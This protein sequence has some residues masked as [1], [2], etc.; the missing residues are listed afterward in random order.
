MG[1]LQTNGVA[2][3]ADDEARFARL[4]I[5]DSE[6][7]DDSILI[8]RAWEIDEPYEE[9]DGSFVLVNADS[10][11]NV[12]GIERFGR[13]CLAIGSTDLVEYST[14]L[15]YREFVAV[16]RR[17]RIVWFVE[18]AHALLVADDNNMVSA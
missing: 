11:I 5:I 13:L 8:F 1:N 9:F 6:V 2:R 10:Q 15:H 18:A 3:K 14:E 7:I 17:G 12:V 16:V 4:E